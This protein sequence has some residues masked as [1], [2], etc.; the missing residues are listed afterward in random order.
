MVTVMVRLKKSH[1]MCNTFRGYGY[2]AMRLVLDRELKDLGLGRGMRSTESHST[3]IYERV[4][5]VH[6][7]V[8]VFDH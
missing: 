7:I 2:T 8:P 4:R 5:N 6:V 3:C 1:T